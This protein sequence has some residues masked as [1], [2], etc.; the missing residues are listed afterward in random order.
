V[1]ATE[2]RVR[3]GRRSTRGLIL[4]FS[5]PRIAVIAAAATLVILG[6]LVDNA[7]G[8]VISA[9]VWAPLA[10]T[11]FVRVGGRPA[12]EWAGTATQFGARKASGQ[13][14][15]RAV[16][17]LK[18]RPAGTLALPGDATSLRL[19][20]DETSGAVMVHDPHRQTLTAIVSV[21]HPAFVLLDTDDRTQRVS[22]WGQ[23][24]ASLAQTGT[25]AAIQVLEAAVP[26]PAT[27]QLEW[28]TERGIHDGG[29]ADRQ[30]QTLLDQV[31]LAAGTHRTTISLSLDMRAAAR[32]IKAAGRGVAG[33]AEVLRGDMSSLT[34]SL[35]Q[36]GLA[37]GRC[38]SEPELA[39]IIRA[40]YDPA[41]VIDPRSDPGARLAH[42]GPLAISEH[43]DRLRHDS[44]WSCVLWVSEWPRIDVAADFLHSII[45]APGVRR[46]LSLIA[47]PLPTDVALRQIRKEKTDAVADMAHKEKV[48]QIADLSD[49]QEYQDLL[50]R[51]RSV[52]SGHTDVEFAG[53]IAVTATDP[54]ALD[55]ARAQ[56]TRAAAQAAC[57]VRPFHGRQAQGFVC[58][59]LP[60]ARSCF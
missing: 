19:H 58:A 43:W 48:G 24:Y 11:A 34:D 1:S 25:C 60:L 55:A 45:F 35:R 57:E 59:A 41:I 2:I 20:L 21:S 27:G 15:Y 49:A 9:I 53:L 47:R 26:D 44:G 33:A 14:Q 32:A 6:M 56:I 31:R 40:A 39:A 18:P 50:E 28:Y 16:H 29:W 51:E 13:D 8:L 54:D 4:G 52:V 46:S 3:F 30:Y 22:R 37:V 42:A 23:A 5:A 7:A 10:A 38:L 36:A 17:P 12:V